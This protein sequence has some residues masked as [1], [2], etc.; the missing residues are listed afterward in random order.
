MSVTEFLEDIF[1]ALNLASPT[2]VDPFPSAYSLTLDT[3][4]A[5]FNACE[6]TAA[7]DPATKD[8]CGSLADLTGKPA[9]PL[10]AGNNDNDMLYV[11]SLAKLFALY[12]AFELKARVQTQA[13]KMIVHGLSTSAAGW[14]NKVYDELKKAWQP[15]LNAAFPSLPSGMPQFA[16]I[17]ALSAT[18]D[19]TFTA[20]TPALTDADIDA[21]GENGSPK[22]KYR[23]WL[24]SMM[25][26]SNNTA[27]SMS[28]RPLSYPYLNGVLRNAGFFDATAHKGLWISG[29]Y[30][31]NDWVRGPG[32]KAG[33][34]LAPRF[35]KAQAR[36]KSNFTGTSLQ[37]ARL[38][39]LLGQGKLFDADAAA[40]NDMISIMTGAQGIGSYIQSALLSA[41]PARAI[42]A[43]ASKIG[44]GDDAFSHDCA[45]IRVDRAADP[46]NPLQFVEVI[47][48][49]PPSK[50]RADLDQLAVAYYDCITAQHP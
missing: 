38:L 3:S 31:G 26:W 27:A 9:S 40:C 32:N 37:V 22:G 33:Q 24:R 46:A 39:T 28:I 19:A 5:A 10:Y 30:L 18:G 11:G 8:L 1:E 36:T 34:P 49:S 16:T 45:L 17:F 4:N 42:S 29:D 15:K 43:I 35:A 25:R 50:G 44:F 23:D 12:V 20:Q 48:G 41:S 14:E 2:P 47:L 21:I 6:N 7:T 13:K